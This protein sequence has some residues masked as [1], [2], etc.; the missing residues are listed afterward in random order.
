MLNS[1]NYRQINV[2]SPD[3]LKACVSLVNKM[4]D[5]SIKETDGKLQIMLALMAPPGAPALCPAFLAFYNG[6]E[7]EAKKLIEPILNL[8]PLATMGGGCNYTNTTQL[9]P[10]IEVAGYER[11][12]ASSAHMD[13]PL[14]ESLILDVF[15]R[16]REVAG[17]YGDVAK[18]SKCI[19]DI[20]N[21]EK[22]AAV[23]AAST[24]YAGRYN[25]AWL[26]PD[27]QWNNPSLDAKM[28]EEVTAITA[29]VR[30]KLQEKKVTAEVQ[31]DGQRDVTAIYPNISAGGEEKAK[32]VFGSN[33]PR[34]QAL[35]HKY[36]PDSMW[37][38]W[39]PIAPVASA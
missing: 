23:P 35:K 18:P 17:K 16:F 5:L 34:L 22:V 30:E 14:D 19:L 3:K 37:N 38:K 28:R 21:Y 32:S 26:M 1:Q 20:R 33:L 39:F 10:G 6:P 13:Y 4:H 27:L 31:G 15:E 11:Y 24:A 36:D 9:P 7:D 12:A 2:F 29:F 8:E 25:N